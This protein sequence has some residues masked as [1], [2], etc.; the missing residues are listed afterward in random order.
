MADPHFGI[1]PEGHPEHAAYLAA[2]RRSQA[3]QPGEVHPIPRATKPCTPAPREW[4]N[5][6]EVRDG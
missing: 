1:R 4:R 2:L 6:K 5:P 3:E